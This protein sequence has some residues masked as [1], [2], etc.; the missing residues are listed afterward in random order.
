MRRAF[1]CS[2]LLAVAASPFGAP[3]ATSGCTVYTTGAEITP[4]H[5]E[6]VALGPSTYAHAAVS[7]WEIRRYD[8][9]LGWQTLA[10][11]ESL[12]GAAGQGTVPTVLGDQVQLVIW[13]ALFPAGQ[14]LINVYRDGF[15]TASSSSS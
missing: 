14:P 5:C 8:D 6:F 13:P 3:A 1:F 15:V 10:T 2:I 11:A 12:A 4:W 7:R 9:D